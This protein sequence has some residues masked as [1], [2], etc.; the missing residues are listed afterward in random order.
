MAP[1]RLE[2]YFFALTIFGA[3]LLTFFLLKPFATYLILAAILTYFL[4]P[5]KKL[6]IRF[7]RSESLCAAILIVLVIVLVVVPSI[8]LTSHLVSQ[9]SSAYS[10]FKAEH[11]LQRLGDFIRL[12]TGQEVQFQKPLLSALETTRDFLLGAAPNFLGSLTSLVLGLFVMFFVMYYALQ[13][14][15]DVA[16]KLTHLIPLETELKEKMLEELRAVLQGV[17]YGQVITALVQGALGGVGFLVFGVGNAVFWSA[18]M[19]ILSFIPFVGSAI[20]WA[21]AGIFLIIEGNLWRGLGLL[22]YSGV[23]VTSIDH[24][25]KP[26]LISGKS[27]IH[28]VVVLIGVLGGLKLFGFIGLVIGP[29]VLALLIRLVAFY[30]EVYLAKEA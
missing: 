17:L 19:T 14:S 24:V 25:M 10:S 16:H 29:L 30:D 13:L 26:R 15:G 18:I 6:L 4:F 2:K 8:Y 5:I 9:V 12:K 28:P 22:I 21:P 7:V 1:M 27:K 23:I 20:V 11:V 3:L